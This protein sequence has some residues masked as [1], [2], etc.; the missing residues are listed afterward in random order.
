MSEI[1]NPIFRGLSERVTELFE[2]GI[3]NIW[4]KASG[5]QRYHITNVLGISMDE[6]EEA[7]PLSGLF[8][9]DGRMKK[10][11][12]NRLLQLD[13]ETRDYQTTGLNGK[14]NDSLWFRFKGPLGKS[15]DY[16]ES[17]TAGNEKA[18]EYM[19]DFYER[20]R[21]G[22]TM[23]SRIFRSPDVV[24]LI[25]EHRISQ[26]T[27]AQNSDVFA[28]EQV[29]DDREQDDCE[30]SLDVMDT[31]TSEDEKRIFL[32]NFSSVDEKWQRVAV[33]M[34]LRNNGVDNCFIFVQG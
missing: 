3:N 27:A 34:Y 10:T 9:T 4:M 8:G 22:S 19:D 5:E 24:A 25:R 18:E 12:W 23:R 32:E 13:I 7:I 26:L 16:D 1:R 33:A 20:L 21:D 11:S 30:I 17:L 15:L 31:G 29:L 6:W 28:D 14:R 2:Y